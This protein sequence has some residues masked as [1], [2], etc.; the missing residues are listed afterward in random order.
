MDEDGSFPSG[1]EYIIQLAVWI[2]QRRRGRFQDGGE[3][4]SKKVAG[5]PREQGSSGEREAMRPDTDMQA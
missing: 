4:D 3:V 2:I 5:L 1:Q